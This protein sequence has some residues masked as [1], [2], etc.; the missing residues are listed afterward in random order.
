MAL[1][2]TINSSNPPLGKYTCGVLHILQAMMHFA[3]DLARRL[4][5]LTR[6][7]SSCHRGTSIIISLHSLPFN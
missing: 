2:L 4:N 6:R 5:K 7:V 1:N 3:E